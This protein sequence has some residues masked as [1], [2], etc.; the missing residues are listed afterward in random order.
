MDADV[1]TRKDSSM[2]IA[3]GSH[4]FRCLGN[5]AQ[6]TSNCVAQFYMVLSNM[7]ASTIK[8]Y[9]ERGDLQKWLLDNI[10]D[11]EL[12]KRISKIGTRLS[13][14]NLKKDLLNIVQSCV[15]QLQK[16]S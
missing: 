5:C 8:F 15:I 4:F 3:K 9:Y 11:T 2:P 13:G 16:R 14:E 12:G 10:G 6:V 7:D 1:D